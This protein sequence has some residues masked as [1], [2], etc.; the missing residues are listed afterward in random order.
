MSDMNRKN[1]NPVHN[2]GARLVKRLQD[3]GFSDIEIMIFTSS[4]EKALQ[5]LKKLNV[6]MNNKIKVTT[7]TSDAIKFLV[8]N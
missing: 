1:E 5:E 8:E 4:R 6:I 7:S 3:N 2:A